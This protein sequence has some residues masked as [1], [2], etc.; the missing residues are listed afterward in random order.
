MCLLSGTQ[1]Q[2]VGPLRLFF[3]VAA[4]SGYWL[5]DFPA[6]WP[7]LQGRVGRGMLVGVA[8]AAAWSLVAARTAPIDASHR[9]MRELAVREIT[10]ATYYGF[11]E[12]SVVE[13]ARLQESIECDAS[14]N[15]AELMG[16]LESAALV[17]AFQGGDGFG[18]PLL[19]QA[20][21]T[22]WAAAG[23]ALGGMVGL[24]CPGLALAI[25]SGAWT[26]LRAI[27][28]TPTF[29]NRKLLVPNEPSKKRLRTFRNEAEAVAVAGQT[30]RVDRK[31]KY[32]LH[33]AAFIADWLQVSSMISNHKNNMRLA[34]AFSK[35][36]KRRLGEHVEWS[37]TLEFVKISGEWLRLARV[38]ADLVAM[39][40]HRQWFKREGSTL[41]VSSSVSLYVDSSP[42]WKGQELFAASV[43][44]YST[45]THERR[46]LPVIHL[47]RDFLDLDGK[48]LALLWQLWLMVGPTFTEMRRY[49][50]LIRCVV[51]DMGTERLLAD[52]PDLLPE[53]FAQLGGTGDPSRYPREVRL[54]PAAVQVQGWKHCMDLLIRRGL[55]SMLFFPGWL[56][57]FKHVCSFLRTASVAEA[58]GKH[59]RGRGML[60]LAPY[61]ES[62]SIPTFANWRWGTLEN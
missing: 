9:R 1:H 31:P 2:A 7:P 59:F 21:C 25:V 23:M 45:A 42:Q 60:I 55:S 39:L 51:T 22:R 15:P 26:C 53:F 38:R 27:A 20:L 57:K 47:P 28:I 16:L 50:G 56:E 40:L 5:D 62:A 37:A 29:A 14:P 12:N 18:A 44:Y 58:L 52:A 3:I 19:F 17:P 24:F 35:V 13:V 8:L 43:D 11:V 48:A 4:N 10:S 33:E 49:L 30:G 46:L 61:V 34:T 41:E 6:E 36:L 54:F 32:R